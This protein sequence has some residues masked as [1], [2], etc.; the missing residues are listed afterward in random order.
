VGASRLEMLRAEARYHR[1]RVDLYRAKILSGR[2]TSPARLRELEQAAALAAERLAHAER[3][4]GA[5]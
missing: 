3:E 5:E 1:Q 4:A 2:A